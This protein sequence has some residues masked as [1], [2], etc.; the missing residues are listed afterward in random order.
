MRCRVSPTGLINARPSQPTPSGITIK[1]ANLRIQQLKPAYG[2]LERPDRL[3]LMSSLVPAVVLA[4][5]IGYGVGRWEAAKRSSREGALGLVP[6]TLIDI[7]APLM[8]GIASDPPGREP[9]IEYFS[10]NVTVAQLAVCVHPH[11]RQLRMSRV[12]HLQ[13]PPSSIFTNNLYFS[14][15]HPLF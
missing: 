8:A 12:S 4:L 1:A 3:N 13:P 15:F 7:S 2:Q 5:A 6:G 9:K 11:R 10:H 14:F